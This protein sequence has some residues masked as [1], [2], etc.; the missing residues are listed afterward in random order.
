MLTSKTTGKLIIISLFSTVILEA[1]NS[2]LFQGTSCNTNA[3]QKTDY[4]ISQIIINLY[5]QDKDPSVQPFV[6][7]SI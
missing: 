7:A 2:T 1:S 6:S 4:F 3:L 5:Y